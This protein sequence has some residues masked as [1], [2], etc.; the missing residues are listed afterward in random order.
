MFDLFVQFFCSPTFP[1]SPFL[2][3]FPL[4]L[5]LSL[6]VS[7]GRSRGDACSHGDGRVELRR[8]LGGPP[9]R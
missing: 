5:R 3:P 7:Q 1:L 8:G 9:E 4:S 2:P 6:G